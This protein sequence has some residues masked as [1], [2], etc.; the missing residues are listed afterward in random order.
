MA[1]LLK[2]F[3]D[4]FSWKVM[5]KVDEVVKHRLMLAAQA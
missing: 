1:M 5:N 2:E 4:L 3:N